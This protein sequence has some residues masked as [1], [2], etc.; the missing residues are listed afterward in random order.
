ML[1]HLSEACQE[2]MHTVGAAFPA[3]LALPARSCL[4]VAGGLA[5]RA[6]SRD[7]EESFLR[8]RCASAFVKTSARQA[9]QARKR[10]PSLPAASVGLR[11]S[12]GLTAVMHGHLS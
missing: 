6:G 8:A 7:S 3:R 2:S 9:A 5:W 11:P 4:A 10:V 1:A 12:S